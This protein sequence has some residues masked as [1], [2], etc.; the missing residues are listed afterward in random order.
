MRLQL[1]LLFL[2]LGPI[3]CGS[4]VPL[5]EKAEPEKFEKVPLS[6]VFSTS[7]QKP[8][9]PLPSGPKE[10]GPLLGDAMARFFGAKP[11]ASNIFLTHGDDEKKAY[12]NALRF[13]EPTDHLL[14]EVPE[15]K[16][17]LAVFLG[18]APVTLP[19]NPPYWMLDAVEHRPDKWRVSYSVARK[20]DKGDRNLH[21]FF[22]L[23]AITK[24]A[25]EIFDLELFDTDA[26]S[27]VFV[28]KVRLPKSE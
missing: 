8:L 11:R 3:G 2:F 19:G 28:R 23:V 21:A 24:P 7:I 6:S 4:S 17:W 5:P 9:K 20:W 13:H 1:A 10:A 18:R 25:A 16:L 22:Y 15:T 14:R 27:V 26:K 12:A